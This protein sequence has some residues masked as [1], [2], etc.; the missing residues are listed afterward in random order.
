MVPH[1]SPALHSSHVH[2]LI[3][4]VVE[5]A[6]VGSPLGHTEVRVEALLIRGGRGGRAC[7]ARGAQI[8]LIV[9]DDR[10]RGDPP[11]RGPVLGRRLAACLEQ[12]VF[13]VRPRGTADAASSAA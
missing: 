11:L 9:A 5:S 6:V 2:P 8:E 7:G 12:P 13:P 1:S 4:G 10:P 3:P